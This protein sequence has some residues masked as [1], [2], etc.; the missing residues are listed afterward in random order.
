Q[1]A[2]LEILDAVAAPLVVHGRATVIA[3]DQATPVA[4]S[5]QADQPRAGVDLGHLAAHV[6]ARPVAIAIAAAGGAV[7]AIADIADHFDRSRP[8]L[9]PRGVQVDA[10]HVAAL[11]SLHG[12]LAALV[13]QARALVVA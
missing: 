8:G 13:E 4:R 9:A 6:G 10:H 12:P 7:A 1:V 5:V 2:A 3:H 11:E